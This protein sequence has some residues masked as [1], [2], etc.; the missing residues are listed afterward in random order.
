MPTPLLPRDPA[1]LGGYTLTGR[2][3]SG[4]FGVIF[5]ATAPSGDQVAIKLLNNEL[6]T[7]PGF[8]TTLFM[9]VPGCY[10]G[11]TSANP[12]GEQASISFELTC[13]ISPDQAGGEYVGQL[14]IMD[15]LGNNFSQRLPFTI[16]G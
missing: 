14:V 3:G 15:A 13:G 9:S 5:Q 16:A 6:S 8:I 11:N 12:T 10:T 2:L 1:D 4:G 7:D